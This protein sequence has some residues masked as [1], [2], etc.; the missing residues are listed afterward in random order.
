MTAA[1]Y[2]APA[3]SAQQTSVETLNQEEGG[4]LGKCGGSRGWPALSAKSGPGVPFLP[5]RLLRS[6]NK[7]GAAAIIHLEGLRGTLL[8][9][10]Q[11]A[12]H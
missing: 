1:G 11:T 2:W 9:N 8:T 6:S 7:R 4:G 5:I 3:N 10:A 12:W